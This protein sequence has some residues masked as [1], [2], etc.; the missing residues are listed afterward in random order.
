MGK[1]YQNKNL[2]RRRYKP[3]AGYPSKTKIDLNENVLSN[4]GSKLV[5][6]ERRNLQDRGTSTNKTK[7]TSS[8]ALLGKFSQ[9]ACMAQPLYNHFQHNSPVRVTMTRSASACS[10]LSSPSSKSTPLSIDQGS[11]TPQYRPSYYNLELKKDNLLN[12][13]RSQD[14]TEL[15]CDIGKKRKRRKKHTSLHTISPS[16]KNTYKKSKS[17]HDKIYD[18]STQA[19]KHNLANDNL[20]EETIKPIRTNSIPS[21]GYDK[22]TLVLLNNQMHAALSQNGLLP[23]SNKKHRHTKTLAR[24]SKSYD[25]RANYKNQPKFD[26]S[27]KSTEGD[28]FK[29]NHCSE[30]NTNDKLELGKMHMH[31]KQ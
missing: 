1:T 2:R 19:M 26:R 9:M 3:R 11:Q 18:N 27:N 14:S 22:K 29:I 8:T 30:L 25:L 12:H 15:I 13:D 20:D 6:D 16:P 24:T 7:Q 10:R 31:G 23:T 21:V 28:G 17:E 4:V 5:S